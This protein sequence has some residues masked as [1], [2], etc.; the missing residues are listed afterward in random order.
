ML[1]R[2][3]H[4]LLLRLLVRLLVRLSITNSGTQIHA[5]TA[6]S[7]NRAVLLW[8]LAITA[9]SALAVVEGNPVATIAVAAAIPLLPAHVEKLGRIGLL[10]IA[11]SVFL[12]GPTFLV[13]AAPAALLVAGMPG[14]S[15]V[16]VLAL[17]SSALLAHHIQSVP[18]FAGLTLHTGS[19]TFLVIPSVAAAA[20]FGTRIGWRAVAWL[21]TGALAAFL[22]IDAGAGRWITYLTF[23]SPLFRTLAA[24]VPVCAAFPW[25]APQGRQNAERGGE[26]MLGAAIVGSV[27]TLLIP[28]TPIKLV[29]FDESHGRWETV[30]SPF[31]PDDFGRAVNYTYSLLASYGA[32]FVGAAATF[33]TEDNNLPGSDAV[34]VLKMPTKPLSGEFSTRLEQWVREGGR[35]LV[36]ADHTDLYDTAQHLN[37]FLSTRFALRVNSDAVFDPQGM[38]TVPRTE[39]LAALF[40]R[41]DARA[42]PLP[43]Q[44]GAS[45]AAMPANAVELATFGPSFSEPGDYSRPN[46]FGSFLPRVSLRFG[47]HTAVAAF[48]AGKGAVAIIMDSTPWSNFSIFKEQYK[49]LFRGVIHALS[50][51]A[52]LHVWGWSAAALGLMTMVLAFWRL[53][54]TMAIGGLTLGLTVGA[55]T[56]VGVASFGSQV[57]GRDFGLKVIVG[58][59]AKLEFLKQLV[60]PGERNFSRIVSAMSKYGLA[61]SA[62]T[63]GAEIPRLANAKRWL[64]IQPD[65]RQLPGFEDVIAHL[66]AGGDLT[67]LFAPEQVAHLE[68]RA[69]LGALGLYTQEAVALAVT[70]DA[71][72]GQEGLL[73]RRGAAIM[74]DTRVL[75]RAFPTSLLKDRDAD[76]F[77]QSYTVRPTVFPRTSGLLSLGFSADQFSDIAIGEVWEGIQ[78][79]SIGRLRERQLAA[80]L[81]GK[82]LPAPFPE[83]LLLPSSGN[84]PARLAAYLLMEDGKT[85]LTGKFDADAIPRT[86]APVP[87]PIENPVGYL[88]DLRARS[89]FF[90]A[91]SCPRKGRL[92]QCQARMLGPDMVEWMV[93]W[94]SSE[95]GRMTAVELLHE[96]SFSGLGRT[97]NVVFGE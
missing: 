52:A 89:A 39:R 62:S 68:V 93:S 66:R 14:T 95:D 42:Q 58:G 73:N 19:A 70:E 22:A 74:R 20:S 87:S 4:R 85:V 9:G 8:G 78:P 54:A 81:A 55:A 97:L 64:L 5:S 15:A 59:T 40:G 24:L 17:A 94:A 86:G 2:L 31:G 30:L 16:S 82:D 75:T 48:G 60:G 23:T 61:P 10:V 26:W 21:L 25:L 45:L 13:L 80:A 76:Q 92:T 67:V 53:P 6:R 90:I 83:G 79:A 65:S 35:L 46:R 63:P 3:L 36:V 33:D 41:I 72:P 1:H 47:N 88:L 27:V 44:T 57:E 32:Q 84:A 51:P 77:V 7:S 50:R 11:V 29:V 37:G 96:R 43:W 18:S 12:A 49:H 38:P 56:Q 71:R 28:T 91:S 34:F 69:W